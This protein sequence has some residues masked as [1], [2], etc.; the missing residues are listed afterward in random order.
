MKITPPILSGEM[1]HTNLTIA[2]NNPT[3][4]AY[5]P[6]MSNQQVV[7]LRAHWPIL[8]DEHLLPTSKCQAAYLW[9]IGGLKISEIFLGYAV[10]SHAAAAHWGHSRDAKV[11]RSSLP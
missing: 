7:S 6:G 8:L 4:T 1:I 2:S 9:K 10:G 5:F 3:H 11:N